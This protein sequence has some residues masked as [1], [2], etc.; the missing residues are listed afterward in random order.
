M[1]T[2]ICMETML[3]RISSNKLNFTTLMIMPMANV[4]ILPL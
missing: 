4:M 3:N 2:L 1:E